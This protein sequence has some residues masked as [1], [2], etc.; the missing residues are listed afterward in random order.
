MEE[1]ERKQEASLSSTTPAAQPYRP[2]IASGKTSWRDRVAAKEG[3]GAPSISRTPS[4]NP[5]VT[6]TASSDSTGSGPWRR[7][8]QSSAFGGSSYAN[9]VDGEK[10]SA[11]STIKPKEG[12]SSSESKPAAGPPK[13]GSGKWS[14]RR[15]Q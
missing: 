13:I 4:E 10:P 1:I 12:G 9:G 8:P 2:P 3:A 15:G 7:P 11:F 14:S 5:S 6:R